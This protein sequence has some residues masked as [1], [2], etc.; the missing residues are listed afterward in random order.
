MY[1]I[2]IYYV[3][4]F[5]IIAICV[6]KKFT[7]KAARVFDEMKH[8]LCETNFMEFCEKSEIIQL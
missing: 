5:S 4:T 1:G 7:K 2:C 3:L 8:I 6:K